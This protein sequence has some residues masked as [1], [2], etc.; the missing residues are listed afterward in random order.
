MEF[1]G[2]LAMLFI[3]AIAGWLSGKI[4]EGRGFGLIGNISSESSAHFWPARFFPLWALASVVGCSLR[5]SLR[6][7]AQ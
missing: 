1:S 3:G 2:V 6:R 4:M 5:F 7:P